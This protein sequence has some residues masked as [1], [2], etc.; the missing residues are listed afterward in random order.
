MKTETYLIGG[1][2]CAACSASVQRVVSKKDGIARC[3]VNLITEKMQVEYDESKITP[4]DIIFAV[5]KAGFTAVLQID[6]LPAQQEKKHFWPILIAAFCSILLLYISMG[7]MLTDRLPIFTF[8]DID[9]NPMGFAVT[10]LILTLPVLLIGRRFFT[11]GI[12]MLLKGHPDMDSLVAVGAGASFIYSLVMTVGIKRIPHAQHNLYFESVAVVITLVMVGKYFESK[13]RRQTASAIRKLMSLSPDTALLI[14]DGT[15]VEVPT[16]SVKVGDILQIKAGDSVPLDGIAL[17]PAVVDESMLTGESIPVQKSVGET[18]TGGS[19]CGH[20]AF[21]MRVTQV[22]NDT[23][24]S[25]IVRFVE[26][27]Q[28]RKAPIAKTA[29]RVAGIFVP[30]VMA[31]AV[32]AALIWLIVG[33]E[34]SFVLRIFTCVLVI[35]CPCALGLAT[36]TAVMVGTGLGAANGILIRNGAALETAGKVR[37]AVFDKTG[38]VTNGT[39]TVTDIIGNDLRK[40]IHVAASVEMLSSHPLAL[41]ITQYAKENNIQ[42]DTVTNAKTFA[43]KGI[44]AKLNH[45]TVL[46]GNRMLMKEYGIRCAFENEEEALSDQ[47]KTPVFVAVSNTVIGVLGVADEIKSSSAEAAKRLHNMGLKVI[48]L[49]G[50]REK[51]AR[52]IGEKFGADEIF[53]GVLPQEKAEIL[54]KLRQKYGSVIMIG[55]GIN[56]APALAEADIGCAVAHGSDIAIESADLILLKNDLIDVARAIRLSRMTLINIKENLFW[57]F[58]YNAVCIPIAAGVLYPAFGFLLNPMIAGLAMSLSSFCVVTNALRLR[59][60]KL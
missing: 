9:R 45:E 13:S 5:T 28:N 19:I 18:V 39:P 10:Q 34:L 44:A 23:T 6:E 30:I 7:Q 60:K 4:A 3:E 27:A 38:T 36:P 26:E 15:V 17:E 14:R 8:C 35:A 56:D 51:V 33:K 20:T 49:S 31:V 53:A 59:S 37:V 42:T 46:I 50:D 32:I 40:I 47:G 2:H 55:D 57:A 11:A 29:D 41:A 25:K 54:Q 21:T 52:H 24:L 43:G 1:M 16:S 48:L 58:C 22:G 12:P